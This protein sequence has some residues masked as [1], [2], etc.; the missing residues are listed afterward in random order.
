MHLQD[1]M[2][3]VEMEVC[4]RN[5]TGL[6]VIFADQMSGDDNHRDLRKMYSE[7]RAGADRFLQ[8]DHIMDS[9]CF[10]D[11]AH[12]CGIQLADF[13]AGAV[14]GFLRGYDAAEKLFAL[15]IYAHVRKTISGTQLGYGMIEIPKR[16]RSRNH[17]EEKFKTDFGKAKIALDDDIP[18]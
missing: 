1:L 8:Y 3:R 16:L 11:S 10:M 2:Q 13:V 7:L 6:A 14:N 17:L 5:P 18:F 12:C 15:Q 4:E 9:I